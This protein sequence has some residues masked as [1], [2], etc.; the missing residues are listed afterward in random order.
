[1]GIIKVYSGSLD[2]LSKEAVISFIF[3]GIEINDD[4]E[5]SLKATFN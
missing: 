5:V 3:Q 1:M 2:F 4:L